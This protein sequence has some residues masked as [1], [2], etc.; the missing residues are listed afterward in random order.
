MAGVVAPRALG[1]GRGS[2]SRLFHVKHIWPD[3]AS[4]VA[5]RSVSDDAGNR[6]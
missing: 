2:G 3:R 5:I 6:E 1:A 4:C